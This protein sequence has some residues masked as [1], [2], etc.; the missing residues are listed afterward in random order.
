MTDGTIT[1]D[2]AIDNKG[3]LKDIEKQKRIIESATKKIQSLELKKGSLSAEA[4]RLGEALERSGGE[5]AEMQ[6]K[7]NAKK[8]IGLKA[9]KEETA[10]YN[11]ALRENNRIVEALNKQDA[12]IGEI[13]SQIT[14]EQ[15]NIDAAQKRAAELNDKVKR[16]SDAWNKVSSVAGSFMKRLGTM[17]KRVFVFSFILAGLRKVKEYFS[18][19]LKNNTQFQSSLAQMKGAW[20]TAFQPVVEWIMPILIKLMNF[21]TQIGYTIA[22]VFARF[23]GKTVG[24]LKA[25]AKA[26]TDTTKAVKTLNK[27]MKQLAGFDEMNVLSDSSSSSGGAEAAAAPAVTYDFDTTGIEANIDKII[28]IA[29]AALLAIGLILVFTGANIPLGI[30]MIIVGAAGLAAE[31]AINWESISEALQGPIGVI[32]AIVSAAL[33]AIGAILTFS[34]ANI[35]LGIGMMIVGA[36]GLAAVVAVNWDTIS[37]ALQG[38]IGVI[39]AIVSAALLVLGAIFTFTGANLPLGIGMLIVGAAGLAATVAVNWD[40]IKQ[41][42]QGPIGA[43]TAIVG[44]ALLALGAILTFTGAALPLGIG[45]MILGATAAGLAMKAGVNWN[46]IKE[47]LQGPLG[48]VVAIVSAAL[49]ALGAILCFTGAGLPLGIGLIAVG[50]AGLAATA[51][52]NWETV[53]N[54]IKTVVSSLLAIASGALLAMGVVLCLSGAGLPLGLGLIAAGLAGTVLA[55]KLDDN[56]ITRAVKNMVNG[57]IGLIEGFINKI[58]SGVNW[59][60]DQINKIGFDVPDWVPGIGGKRFGFNISHVSTVTLPRLAEGAV[61]PANREFLAVLGDQ[62]TGT[63]IETPLATMVE[64]FRT[65]METYGGGDVTIP[66]YLDGKQIA[67]HVININQQRQFASNY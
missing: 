40:T 36:A 38:P 52:V 58:I 53:K 45:M 4:E 20:R 61:I 46:T 19:V 60:V 50:A 29:S 16:Q 48:K 31:A 44:V 37:E 34:G 21:L 27:Q 57:L 59:L 65:A 64:A 56:P 11:A 43:V 54:K 25:S 66:I 14:A 24:G 42:L 5:L 1:F 32:T 30:G 9:T 62:K 8:D 17:I 26:A 51:S 35:P 22:A 10:E 33:L 55:N 15:G 28:A 12:K 41:K 39:T 13:N 7:I 49:L 23:T 18:D 47:K 67:R 63:N 6:A 3:L 2:T